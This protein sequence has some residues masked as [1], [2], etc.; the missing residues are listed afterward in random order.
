MGSHS[1]TSQTSLV[2]YANFIAT[3]YPTPVG[4]PVTRSLPDFR[5]SPD[6]R[7]LCSIPISTPGL[8]RPTSSGRPSPGSSCAP[9]RY[10][11]SDNCRSSGKNCGPYKSRGRDRTGSCPIRSPPHL[12]PISAAA[13]PG[14]GSPVPPSISPLRPPSSSPEVDPSCPHLFLPVSFLIRV[15]F[16]PGCDLLSSWLLI[17]CW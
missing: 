5:H 2:D 7:F 11:T 8:G 6:V 16:V 1:R 4:R 3:G 14:S 17:R 12:A 10:R 9:I 13:P 15:G